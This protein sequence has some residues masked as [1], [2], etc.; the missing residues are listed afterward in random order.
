MTPTAEPADADSEPA[1]PA[2]P[3]VELVVRQR[4]AIEAVLRRHRVP[5]GEAAALVGAAVV[6][7]TAGDR[8]GTPP[9]G[10]EGRLVR[11]LEIA[12]ARRGGGAAGGDALGPLL[13]MAAG[14]PERGAG[15]AAAPATGEP[16]AAATLGAAFAARIAATLPE[17]LGRQPASA[18]PDRAAPADPPAQRPQDDRRFDAVVDAVERRWQDL[19]RRVDGER[20]EAPA[21]AAGAM[22]RPGQADAAPLATRGVV[23]HLLAAAAAAWVED[24]RRARELAALAVRVVRELD[25]ELYGAVSLADLEARAVGTL[26]NAERVVG[27]LDAAEAGFAEAGRLLAA[28]S[29][30][31]LSRAY[32]LRLQATLRR[33]QGRCEES[34][35]LLDQAAAI[36]RWLGDRHLEGRIMLQRAALFEEDDPRQA[37]D[38]MR[39]G[40]AAIDVRRE[41]RLELVALH[42]LAVVHHRAGDLDAAAALLPRVAAAAGRVGG[43]LDRLRLRWLAAQIAVDRGDEAAAAELAAVRD[44]LLAEG[45]PLDALLAALDLAGHHLARGSSAQARRLA[46]EL[47]PLVASRPLDRQTLAAL[48]LFQQAALL[49]HATVALVRATAARLRRDRQARRRILRAS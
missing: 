41:P 18:I 32:L 36:Y 39:R 6:A 9:D 40:L 27:N 34:L 12:C 23:E 24:A 49:G 33:A 20:R 14:G 26:A 8:A 48:L 42:D 22:A 11:A 17:T 45:L 43:R 10:S 29:R 47:V 30:D 35:R 46:E 16:P 7:V 15:S 2:G 3:T 28:G 4:E 5:S 44:A 31:P 38:L 13:A 25:A 21:R 19:G 1:H 37:A